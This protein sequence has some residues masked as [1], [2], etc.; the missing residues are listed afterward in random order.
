MV[1]FFDVSDFENVFF[2][3]QLHSVA[4]ELVTYQDWEWDGEICNSWV[5][6]DFWNNFW[7]ELKY[8]DR[9]EPCK[10]FDI[11]LYFFKYEVPVDIDP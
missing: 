4:N 10:E 8:E 9:E 5:S 11:V 6:I 7:N 3:Q 2:L 1:N